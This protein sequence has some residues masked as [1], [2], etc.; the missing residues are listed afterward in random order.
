[1][2]DAYRVDKG[3]RP[4]FDRVMAGLQ[5]LKKHGVDFNTLTTVHRQNSQQPLE[6]Y[7]FL[8][9]VGSGYL[10]FI[11]IVERNAAAPSDHDLWLAPPPDHADAAALDAQVTDWSVRPAEFGDFLCRIFDD[12]VRRD[13]GK[14][15]VQQFDAALANWVGAPAGICVFSENCGRALAIEHNG[16]VYSCDHYVYPQY[17]LGNMMNASLASLVDSPR[18][19]AFGLAKS[20]TLPSDCRQCPVR[21]ACHGECPKHRFLRTASGEPGLNYLC[22]GYKKFFTHIDSPMQTMAALLANRQ[23]PAR[24][25]SLPQRQWLPGKCLPAAPRG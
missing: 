24:I 12:W 6:V 25:M 1:L 4:T 2:H 13:V 3:A 14:V 5:V 22:A 19:H 9:E 11:P 18:Q 10:Q 15:F 17:R 8:R 21:F 7:R 20:A 16:D 23:P